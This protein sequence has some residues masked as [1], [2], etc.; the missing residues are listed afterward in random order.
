MKIQKKLFYII[1][2]LLSAFSIFSFLKK[3]RVSAQELKYKEIEV[4]RGDTLWSISKEYNK[5][6]LDIR[7]YIFLIEEKN[8]IQ[9]S[10]IQTG[11][12]LYIPIIES[13]R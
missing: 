13:G 7:K 9:N 8:N 11:D 12:V 6:S 3:D 1:V 5:S 2:L 10:N 4:Q